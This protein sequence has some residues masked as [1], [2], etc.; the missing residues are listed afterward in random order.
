MRWN[1]PSQLL[2]ATTL[3]AA[4]CGDGKIARNPVSGT[5]NVDGKP[6]GGAIVTFCPVG[7]SVPR[8][9]EHLRPFSLS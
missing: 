1:H 6:A 7:G 2:L 5:V 3:V 9:A 4:G 8:L